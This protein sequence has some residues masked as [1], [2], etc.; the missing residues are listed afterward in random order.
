VAVRAIKETEW[1]VATQRVR[2]T[3]VQR[4]ALE[5]V[6]RHTHPTLIDVAGRTRRRM[7]LSAQRP[8]RKI[9]VEPRQS[10]TIRPMAK[11]T[12]R[13]HTAR[14][15]IEVAVRAFAGLRF[16]TRSV[17]L[18]AVQTHMAAG[19]RKAGEVVLEGHA[20]GCLERVAGLVGMAAQTVI[21]QRVVVRRDMADAAR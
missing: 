2:T 13:A 9:V 8:S 4:M 6:R 17:A 21:T 12:F 10:P 11:F 18:G 3:R 15:G 7:V 19:E 5:A 16:G 20:V 14:V 1:M